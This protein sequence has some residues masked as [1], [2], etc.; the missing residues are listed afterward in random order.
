MV[1]KE[2]VVSEFLGIKAFPNGLPT[3]QHWWEWTLIAII[4]VSVA[5]GVFACLW[6]SYR[7]IRSLLRVSVVNNSNYTSLMKYIFR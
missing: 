2:L 6:Y 7:S 5:V 1:K 4:A 3:F